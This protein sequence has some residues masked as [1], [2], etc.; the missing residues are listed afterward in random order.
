MLALRA[1]QGASGYN[2]L[3]FGSVD[4][5]EDLTNLTSYS[6]TV[7]IGSVPTGAQRRY[8]VISWGTFKASTTKP[9]FSSGTINGETLSA[10]AG[11]VAQLTESSSVSLGWVYAEV[12]SGSGDQTLAM[13][14]STS[15]SELLAAAYPV[16]TG[17]AGLSVADSDVDVDSDETGSLSLDCGAGGVILTSYL[18]DS[19]GKTTSWSG[20]GMSKDTDFGT[21]TRVMSTA[22]G[23]F[24]SAQTALAI[25]AT[26][27]GSGYKEVAAGIGLSP[28]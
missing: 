8:L 21:G 1:Q 26:P 25:T 27:S 18:Q 28:A 11:S 20:T 23:A 13:T 24:V 5:D 3:T 16:Y 10:I 22:S 15:C 2:P 19:A 7:N 14:M 6:L 12:A 4:T 9:D 17:P